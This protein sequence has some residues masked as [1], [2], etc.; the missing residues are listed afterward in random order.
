[1]RTTQRSIAALIEAQ[2]N[3][4][5]QWCT[6]ASFLRLSMCAADPNSIGVEPDRDP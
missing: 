4:L 2:S 5:I 1:M 3:K 6:A